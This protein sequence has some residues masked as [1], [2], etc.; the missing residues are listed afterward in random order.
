MT[1]PT[2]TGEPRVDPGP[3]GEPVHRA[4]DT[5]GEIHIYARDRLR[6]L[7]F[8]N[9]VEQSCIDLDHP[10]RLVHAY[11]QAMLLGLLLVRAPKSALLLGLGGGAL[12]QALL[13][14]D[15]G[16]AL[17]AVESRA[18]VVDIAHRHLALPRTDRLRIHVGDAATFA[19][20]TGQRY[21]LALLDLYLAKGMHPD[22]NGPDL[23]AACRARLI[24]GGLLIANHWS[25]DFQENRRTHAALRESF[26]ERVLYLH[27]QGGNSI[28]FAFV[29]AVPGLR[30]AAFLARAQDLGLRLDI[31]LQRLARAFWGQNAEVLQTARLSPDI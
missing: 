7:T 14:C 15:E 28:A 11:T 5:E 30:R 2:G 29:D 18:A 16:L 13:A 22:Q 20:A 1:N 27:I 17:D 21:D 31:P 3:F 8:G 19:R 4:A 10:A 23:L 25:Y 9:R 26:P 12:A 24:R 6:L